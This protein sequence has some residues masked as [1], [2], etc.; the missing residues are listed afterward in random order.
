[1]SGGIHLRNLGEEGVNP[2]NVSATVPPHAPTGD[3]VIAR[4]VAKVN[5]R[6]KGLV[7][8]I[9]TVGVDGTSTDHKQ[10]VFVRNAGF[11]GAATDQITQKALLKDASLA[12]PA[13]VP[14]AGTIFTLAG[15]STAADV[16]KGQIIEVFHDDSGTLGTDVRATFN[17][18]DLIYEASANLDPTI[19]G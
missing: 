19:S 1:M 13:S 6:V 2:F 18:V 11:G 10:E 12:A 5:G 14:A 15:L 17:I 16:K 4:A 7:V 3:A 8:C 9:A